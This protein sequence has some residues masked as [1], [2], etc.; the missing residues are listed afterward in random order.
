M[1]KRMSK[2]ERI[3]VRTLLA[4]DA[5]Y[6]R[7]MAE[8]MQARLEAAMTEARPVAPVKA[9]SRCLRRWPSAGLEGSCARRSV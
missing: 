9:G 3:D 8:T 7:T 5:G 6:R 4:A 2:V 1:T